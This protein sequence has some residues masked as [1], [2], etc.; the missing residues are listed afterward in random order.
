MPLWIVALTAAGAAMAAAQEP[1]VFPTTVEQ[2]LVAAVVLDGRGRPVVD[3][4]QGDFVLVEDGVRQTIRSFD[5]PPTDATATKGARPE[6]QETTASL[7]IVFDDIGLTHAQGTR[8]R[9]AL[10]ALVRSNAASEIVLLA[11]TSGRERWVRSAGEGPASLGEVVERLSGLDSAAASAVMTGTEACLIHWAHDGPT[12]E[13]V[14]ARYVGGGMGESLRTGLAPLI[15]AEAG[16]T[17]RRASGHA[18]RVLGELAGAATALA[19]RVGRRSAVLI[20]A[21]FVRDDSL[22]ELRRLLEASRPTVTLYVLDASALEGAASFVGAPEQLFGPAD[23]VRAAT[24]GATR[25]S[26]AAE[27]ARDADRAAA[28]GAVY[29]AEETGGAVVRRT[30]DLAGGLARIVADSRARYVL[31]YVPTQPVADDHYRTISVG[32]VPQPGKPRK[33]WTVRARRGY[34]PTSVTRPEVLAGA[35]AAPAPAGVTAAETASSPGSESLPLRFGAETLEDAP[36]VPPRVLCRL[37][38]RVDL[39][40]VAFDEADGRRTARLDATFVV[41]AEAA[42]EPIRLQKKIDLDL[43]AGPHSFRDRWLPVQVDVPL[44][45][46]LRR[47]T[48]TVRDV[49][50]GRMGLAEIVIDVPP[51]GLLRI[52]DRRLSAGL[53]TDEDGRP[54]AT[55]DDARVF[56]AGTTVFLSFDV[57]GSEVDAVSSVMPVAVSG[58]V[59]R[60]G[61]R[62]ALPVTLDPL[63]SDGRGGLRSLIRIDLNDAPPGDYRFAGRV[64]DARLTRGISFEEPFAVVEAERPADVRP[65]DPELAELLRKAGRYVAEYESA[66]R[67]I[68]AEEE[69]VQRCLSAAPGEPTRRTTRADLVFVRLTGPIPWA[70][71]RDVYE[72]DGKPLRDRTSR[73]ERLFEERS[74][75]AYERAEAILAESSRHNICLERTVNLPTLP[76]VFLLPRNQPRFVFQRRGKA[77]PG[78]PVELEFREVA[79]PTVLRNRKPESEGERDSRRLDL[80]ADGRLWIDPDRGTVVRSEV[81]LRTGR[82]DDIATLTT[83]YRPEP[84]LAM[85]VPDEMRETYEIQA[86]EV[87]VRMRSGSGAGSRLET[88]ARYTRLRRF[89][90]TTDEKA[91]L[92]DRRP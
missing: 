79:R 29:V 21:G 44:P 8:A 12:L 7:A 74:A 43:A 71:F 45:R 55:E 38:A 58:A 9:K 88:V 64:T 11:T 65:A 1:P 73:L 49:A 69:Y 80:P 36:G 54:R 13:R 31:G 39:R 92:P 91:R 14:Q 2:V 24:A 37:T 82:R 89:E 22:P 40:G 30:N 57:F 66:F 83:R 32:L 10:S 63:A 17:C 77:G 68:V 87:P 72:V 62:K 56:A 28:A 26:A 33:G 51:A 18:R 78:E 76:L 25:V 84:S 90:V 52:A 41:A 50:S 34:Y 19:S 6:R 35:A 3:L 85:W 42:A 67:N 60:P 27:G 75:S 70:S 4:K 61:G 47:V 81:R 59:F 86:L 48:A 15:E 53:E 46:G 23:E 5:A 16:A 20:S